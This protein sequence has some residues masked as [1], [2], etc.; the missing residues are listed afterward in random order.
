MVD[1]NVGRQ[2][3]PR[4]FLGVKMGAGSVHYLNIIGII[5]R[6]FFN[7]SCLVTYCIRY[8]TNSKSN[9]SNN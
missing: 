3:L 7:N 2:A 6:A 5:F 8:L 4:A 1:D 9:D